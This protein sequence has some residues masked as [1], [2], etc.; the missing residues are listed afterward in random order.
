M[1]VTERPEATTA[2]LGDLCTGREAGGGGAGE[3]GGEWAAKVA[4]VAHLY[5]ER[6][7]APR[8]HP[9]RAWERQRPRA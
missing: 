7:A 4:D 5:A 9:A 6:R 8:R 3:A 2:L 1:L